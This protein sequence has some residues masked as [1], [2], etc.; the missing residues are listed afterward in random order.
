MQNQTICL[1]GEWDLYWDDGLRGGQQY[2][3]DPNH[4]SYKKWKAQVPGEVHLDLMRQGVL[5]DVYTGLGAYQARWVEEFFWGYRR[6]FDCPGCKE[7]GRWFL[8][9]GG[10]DY[11]AK[12]YLN[13]TLAGS[14]ADY[15]LPCRLE[16]WTELWHVFQ[17]FPLKSAGEAMEHVATFLQRYD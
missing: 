10:L 9:F 6:S 5:D 14:H 15:F 7:G 8:E 11:T 17:M 16:V 12:I 1:N 13:G 4:L 2:W 3:P